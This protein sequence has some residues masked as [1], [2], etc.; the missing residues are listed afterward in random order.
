MSRADLDYIAGLLTMSHQTNA[1]SASKS[2]QT[3]MD[4]AIHKLEEC[5]SLLKLRRNNLS[6]VN[7]L[8]HEIMAIIFLGVHTRKS[9]RWLA[10]TQ[11]CRS[12][13]QIALDCPGLWA[14]VDPLSSHQEMLHTFL[15]RAKTAPLTVDV[16]MTKANNHEAITAFL[17]ANLSRIRTLSL[18]DEV[19]YAPR[20]VLDLVSVFSTPAPLLEELVLLFRWKGV[21][22]TPDFTLGRNCPNLKTLVAVCQ[23]LKWLPESIRGLRELRIERLDEMNEPRVSEFISILEA[24]PELEILCMTHAGPILDAQE[25]DV[26][27]RLVNLRFLHKFHL[28]AFNESCVALLSRITIPDVARW[29]INCEGDPSDAFLDV[30][31]RSHP[32]T[33]VNGITLKISS[34]DTNLS[35]TSF[36]RLVGEKTKTVH[37]KMTLYPNEGLHSKLCTWPSE[38]SFWNTTTRLELR[39]GPSLN[40]SQSHWSLLFGA[41]PGVIFLGIYS[42]RRNL[43]KDMPLLRALKPLN[44]DGAP[45]P[46]PSISVLML[47][48]FSCHPVTGTNRHG[49]DE[50]SK[51]NEEIP[52]GIRDLNELLQK[53]CVQNAR[54]RKLVLRNCAGIKRQ[55]LD[56][57]THWIDELDSSRMETKS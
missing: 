28:T 25:V 53:R 38:N 23:P 22:S 49:P 10:V 36:A 18:K 3:E 41:F 44:Q 17:R 42:K 57:W 37:T 16:C 29:V 32:I 39:L 21:R 24:C 54:L 52:K 50:R 40:F 7:V 20:T 48:G 12:W 55:F 13:R 8:P 1:T 27:K 30:I 51:G 5:L 2:T 56:G 45:I 33:A 35:F 15:E 19:P 11:V 43:I 26:S 46:C 47:D 9:L 31:P 34:D 4:N 6:S 14:S